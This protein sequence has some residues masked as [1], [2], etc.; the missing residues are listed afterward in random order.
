MG[1][2]S[3]LNLAEKHKDDEIL[4]DKIEAYKIKKKLLDKHPTLNIKVNDLISFWGGFHNNFRYTS[5]IYGFDEDGDIY[6]IWD[7]Y[8]FPL[9]DDNERQIEHLSNG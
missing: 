4:L 3:M 5:K 1:N 9:K 8:W 2:I 6:V 7:C